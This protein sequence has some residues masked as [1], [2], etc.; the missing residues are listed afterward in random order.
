MVRKGCILSLGALTLTLCITGATSAIA[1]DSSTPSAP[2]KEKKGSEIPASTP[3]KTG[4]SD[5]MMQQ[6]MA[7]Y[8]Q[9]AY[10]KS[11]QLFRQILAQDAKYMQA[12]VYLARSLYRMNKLDASLKLFAELNPKDLDGQTVYEYALTHF[13]HKQYAKALD[14]FVLVPANDPLFD[15][16]SLY[17]AISAYR[18]K[19]Y[20]RASDLIAKAVVLPN[21]LI[22]MRARYK[23]YITENLNK[24]EAKPE[25]TSARDTPPK[26]PAIISVASPSRPQQSQIA[27]D[28]SAALLVPEAPAAVTPPSPGGYIMN[29]AGGYLNKQQSTVYGQKTVGNN[30]Y[31]AFGSLGFGWDQ[32]FGSSET[33]GTSPALNLLAQLDIE[34]LTF[35]NLDNNPLSDPLTASKNA[36]IGNVRTSG[37]INTA[38]VSVLPSFNMPLGPSASLA[39]ALRHT[40]IV[41]DFKTDARTTN[42]SVSLVLS[43]AVP[44]GQATLMTDAF[45]YVDNHDT[46]Q[47]AEYRAMTRYTFDLPNN[48][49]FFVGAMLSAFEYEKALIDGPGAKYSGFSGLQATFPLNIAVGGYLMAQRVADTHMYNF[50]DYNVITFR[51]DGVTANGYLQC[52]FLPWLTGS[53][54]GIELHRTLSSLNPGE[55]EAHLE[56]DQKFPTSIRN[57]ELSLRAETKF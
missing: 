47:I 46:P 38:M 5:G 55:S 14:G 52:R 29:L 44:L 50:P 45:Q 28:T 18:L 27:L 43:G 57:F 10:A 41:P 15:L 7:L 34:N 9:G 54:S 40:V 39:V 11:A 35:E 49:Q 6:G 36:A 53:I 26:S 48:L 23:T 21:H 37:Q 4:G 56:L 13:I 31:T 17:G 2:P 3:R 32:A 25:K 42:R 1:G 8:N 19:K 24:S 12:K 20:E 16:A 51:E 22:K 30:M 33:T